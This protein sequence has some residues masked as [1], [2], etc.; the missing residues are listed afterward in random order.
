MEEWSDMEDQEYIEEY[1]LIDEETWNM[2]SREK[3]ELSEEWKEYIVS[4]ISER[5]G[6][7]QTVNKIEKKCELASKALTRFPLN[8]KT[9][10][11]IIKNYS[12]SDA[13]AEKLLNRNG[14]DFHPPIGEPQDMIR[15]L[16]MVR[17]H[18]YEKRKNDH[19]NTIDFR[20]LQDFQ[21]KIP[22]ELSNLEKKEIK[23]LFK[24]Y[25][26]VIKKIASSIQ[27]ELI[28]YSDFNDSAKKET[29]TLFEIGFISQFSLNEME[30]L[31]KIYGYKLSP[32]YI[33]FDT[34]VNWI[35]L[36]PENTRYKGTLY[37]STYYVA[38][39]YTKDGKWG[40]NKDEK[41]ICPITLKKLTIKKKDIMDLLYD[42]SRER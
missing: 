35:Q 19:I 27:W 5:T 32:E 23:N 34:F 1:R 24:E 36:L 10:E 33:P 7:K 18:S 11:K 42:M 8:R 41:P 38:Q 26:R 3:E 28:T 13:D 16:E 21:K 37:K 6:K 29:R 12:L 9:L 31:Y 4:F 40:L 17:N 30:E 25:M 22:Q 14:L 15:I 39:Q 2:I 20:L